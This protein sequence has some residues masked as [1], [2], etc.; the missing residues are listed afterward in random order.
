M[1]SVR[2]RSACR[3]SGD[4]SDEPPDR[5]KTMLHRGGA[6][7]GAGGPHA[8]PDR[9]V[10]AKIEQLV[11]RIVLAHGAAPV[12]TPESGR[13]APT[14][15]EVRE[16]ARLVADHD[17][18]VASA[19]VDAVRARGASIATIH[20]QLLAPAASH[21]G[22]L[23]VA[24]RRDFTEVTVGV[25]RLEQLLRELSASPGQEG[26]HQACDPIVLLAPLPGEQHAFGVAMVADFF[27]RA[28]WHVRGGPMRSVDDLLA[29][30]EGEWLDVVGLSVGCYTHFDHIGSAIR[31]VRRSSRNR[32]VGIMIGG[33]A[34]VDHPEL[35]MRVGADAT[36]VDG[37]QAVLQ[38]HQLLS[39]LPRKRPEP[40]RTHG[41]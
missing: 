4:A 18:S 23:W 1:P 15:E 10:Q 27:R 13:D 39:L 28:R 24:D 37:R 41:R 35:A 6:R 38:A 14:A 22:E 3:E 36:A 40:L 30:V 5:A 11:P 9:L 26:E 8:R 2:H 34:F 16:L 12:W 29:C 31:A 32:S 33:P 19:F 17:V 20:L 21:L 7:H 25:W